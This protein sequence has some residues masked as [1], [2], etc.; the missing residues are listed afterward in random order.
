[1][2]AEVSDRPAKLREVR[3]LRQQVVDELLNVLLIP[4]PDTNLV[5]E[6]HRE[7]VGALEDDRLGARRLRQLGHPALPHAVG[8]VLVPSGVDEDEDA[9]VPEGV[10]E[11]LRQ[12]LPLFWAFG[13][14]RG[15]LEDS[16]P[17]ARTGLDEPSDRVGNGAVV[18]S[19]ADEQ[20]G[21]VVRSQGDDI[22]WLALLVAHLRSLRTRYKFVQPSVGQPL[23]R[24]GYAGRPGGAGEV[25]RQAGQ[26]EPGAVTRV[27]VLSKPI[28]AGHRTF[29]VS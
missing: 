25:K 11:L 5:R 13:A 12:V 20:H 6:G 29:Y 4:H 15:G 19:V 18:V 22:R 17:A 3:R 28:I 7:L 2:P 27:M 10:S 14:G 1:M 16:D 8:P 21:P 26:G 23:R 24:A 9:A